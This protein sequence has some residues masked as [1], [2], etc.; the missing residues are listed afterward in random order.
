[1]LKVLKLGN[2]KWQFN[3]EVVATVLFF[4]LSLKSINAEFSGTI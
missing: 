3:S 1:M 4:D 2:C